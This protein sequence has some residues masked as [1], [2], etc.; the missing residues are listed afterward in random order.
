MV[1]VPTVIAFNRIQLDH[2]I[3]HNRLN[4]SSM[5]FHW[6]GNT[7]W[8]RHI[9]IITDN[10][11]LAHQSLYDTT[12]AIPR[13]ERDQFTGFCWQNQGKIV[14]YVKP[15]SSMKDMIRTLA[16]EVAH[17]YCKTSH[18]HT[19][20]RGFSLLLPF[21]YRKFLNESP[22]MIDW[23]MPSE[24]ANCVHRYAIRSSPS[25]RIQ[26]ISTHLDAMERA[27][28]RWD[29]TRDKTGLHRIPS[30][31]NTPTQ[32]IGAVTIRDHGLFTRLSST[33]TY[34]KAAHKESLTKLYRDPSV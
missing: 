28:K 27:V 18:G 19:W 8:N 34:D 1:N 15:R 6:N 26:E 13:K 29:D 24:I 11:D 23:K 16:H 4:L 33:N 3:M 22:E 14:L 31:H 7:G 25:R 9:S 20:R 17:A 10:L 12:Q 21:W 5:I 30:W 32:T 2:T